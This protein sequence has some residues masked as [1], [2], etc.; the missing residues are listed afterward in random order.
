M[1]KF[2]DDIQLSHEVDISEGRDTLQKDPGGLEEW[3]SKNSMKFKMD[4]RSPA[5]LLTFY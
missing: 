3:A 4:I 5:L 2:A 1:T